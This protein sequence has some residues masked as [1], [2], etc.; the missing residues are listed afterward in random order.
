VGG[1]ILI[2]C[3]VGLICGA[4][5]GRADHRAGHSAVHR[6][7][8]RHD[9][10]PQGWALIVGNGG[11][12]S[13]FDESFNFIGAASALGDLG[14]RA[15]TILF[16]GVALIAH[17]VLRYTSGRYVYAVGG[18]REAA[19]LFGLNTGLIILSVYL[20]VG[21]LAGLGGFVLASRLNRRRRSPGQGWSSR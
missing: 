20:I 18:N 12:V 6:H 14:A 17:L 2:A 5:A 1:A 10:L 7:A 16:L 11:P 8:G 4:G 9:R 13:A 19:R 15:R 3:G 21:L